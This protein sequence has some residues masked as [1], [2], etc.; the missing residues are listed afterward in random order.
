MTDMTF[1]E[2]GIIAIKSAVIIVGGILAY[3]LIVRGLK[4]LRRGDY[5]PDAIY[6]LTRGIIRWLLIIIVILL[7]LQQAGVSVTSVWAAL[8]A[9]LLL[10][11]IGFVAVWS[12][13][14]NVLSSVLLI[15]FPPF[16]IGDEIEVTEPTTREGLRGK[17]TRMNIL[18]TVLEENDEQSG[19]RIFISI[20]NNIFLQKT[21]RRRMG[22][23]TTSLKEELL[24]KSEKPDEAE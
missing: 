8:S 11:A 16:R 19:E 22:S 24:E 9:I 20:P 5:L 4:I 6:S 13:L 12:I 21:V 2:I 10:V 17:V 14:S 18:Y 15:I 23:K 7:V 1:T 3:S